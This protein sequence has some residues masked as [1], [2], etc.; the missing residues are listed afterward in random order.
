MGFLGLKLFLR[1][2]KAC[3]YGMCLDDG[4][5]DA[6]VIYFI[7]CNVSINKDEFSLHSQF[8][9]IYSKAS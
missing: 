4:C 9:S 7:F 2:S 3:N 1:T 8:Y 5:Q 6:Q